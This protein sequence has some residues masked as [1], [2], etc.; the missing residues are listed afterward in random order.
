MTLIAQNTDHESATARLIEHFTKPNLVALLASYLEQVQD[1][2]NAAFEVLLERIIDNAVGV[3]LDVLGT[4]VGQPRTDPDD[5]RYR[6]LIRGKIAANKSRA[7][8]PDV[9]AIARALLLPGGETFAIREEPPA[10]MRIRVIDPLVSLDADLLFLML[11][12]S[13][14]AGVRLMLDYNSALAGDIT[15]ILFGSTTGA[16]VASG[17]FGSTTGATMNEGG[18]ESTIGG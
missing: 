15:K 5:E 16:T 12:K 4:I 9:L 2:E 1:L 18:F 7:T 3:Q 17:T 13:R 11:N 8:P 14:A 10:Q 6:S